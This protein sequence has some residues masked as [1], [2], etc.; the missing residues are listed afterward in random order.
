MPDNSTVPKSAGKRQPPGG[1]RKG[2]PN[3]VTKELK[4]MILGALDDAGGQEYLAKQATENPSAFM[5]L[6][7]KVLPVT[8][9]GEGQNGALVV[10][11]KDYTGRKNA[12]D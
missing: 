6:V 10:T 2:K 3:K 4:D 7:G 5:A 9:K 1:S 11:I 12:A 8:L